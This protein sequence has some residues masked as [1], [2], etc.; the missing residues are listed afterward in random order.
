VHNSS[1]ILR[2]FIFFRIKNIA[3]QETGPH[4]RAVNRKPYTWTLRLNA[5]L[6]SSKRISSAGRKP[7]GK[8]ATAAS[9]VRVANRD[10]VAEVLS[11][12]F[13]PRLAHRLKFESRSTSIVFTNTYSGSSTGQERYFLRTNRYHGRRSIAN[14]KIEETQ[15]LRILSLALEPL[16][17]HQCQV[18]HLA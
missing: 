12:A 3:R 4:A 9:A 17:G 16:A 15:W 5:A 18:P 11:N 7:S 14:Y 10:L 13:I 8:S 2:I 6:N 1:K